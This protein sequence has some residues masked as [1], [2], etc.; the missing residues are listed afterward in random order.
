LKITILK[1]NWQQWLNVV[2]A[3]LLYENAFTLCYKINVCSAQWFV[4]KKISWN[5]LYLASKY[6]TDSNATKKVQLQKCINPT[7][8]WKVQLPRS[9]WSLLVMQCGLNK[10]FI[11]IWFFHGKR[12]HN[13]SGNN[14]WSGSSWTMQQ[15][16]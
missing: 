15:T 3:M 7:L 8:I 1:S 14:V 11:I 6:K 12:L 2:K 9:I 16:K 4:F 5:K 13:S 10:F